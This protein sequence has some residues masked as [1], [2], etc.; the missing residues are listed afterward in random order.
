MWMS[1]AGQNRQKNL[2]LLGLCCFHSQSSMSSKTNLFIAILTRR[3]QTI[4]H[5]LGRAPSQNILS[6]LATVPGWRVALPLLL[7]SAGLVVQPCAA[8]ASQWDF[9]GS[10]LIARYYHTGTLL[11]DGKVLVAGGTSARP[12]MFPSPDFPYP[13]I[14]STELYDPATGTWSATGLLN[15]GRL[16]HTATLLLNGK[17]LVAGGWPDHTHN[18]IMASAE[19]Y[20]PATGTWT[21]TGSMNVGR[22]AHTATLLPDGK[23]LVVGASRGFP[24]SAEL[25]DPATG[26][27]TFT[28]STV[29]PLFGYH[30]ATLLANGKVL[31][32][33]GYD[34]NGHVSANAQL[35]DPTTGTWTATGSL[36]TARQDHKAALLP[37]GMVL[38]MGGS[39]FVSGILAS[40][41]LY[42]PATGNWMGANRLNVARW[43]HT[44]TTLPDGTVLVAGGLSRRNSLASAEVY[45]PA[46]GNWIVTDS[47]N[48]AR[49]LHTA[50]LLLDGRVLAAGGNNNGAFVGSAELYES[51]PVSTP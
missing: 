44:A 22:A 25:Y 20:D 5:S 47:L 38:V 9:T 50:T 37:N 34:S 41:E 8:I 19:L 27:W 43:H 42:D 26:H 21:P 51:G 45:D 31:V 11:P 4:T 18:G 48:E 15:A 39:N 3:I 17:V 36:I 6:Q 33:A 49:G 1:L 7:V 30:T 10:L 16:L 46:V 35:Y 12:R 32:A 14:A 29:T 24:N 40:A 23:V 2:Y 28:G 13:G